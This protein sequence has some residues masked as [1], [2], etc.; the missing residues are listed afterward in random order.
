[1]VRTVAEFYLMGM[2][3]SLLITFWVGASGAS[4][5]TVFSLALLS[6]PLAGLTIV[7]RRSYARI[8]NQDFPR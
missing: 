7:A 1:M 5:V 6:W 3:F 8:R 4:Y 2:V